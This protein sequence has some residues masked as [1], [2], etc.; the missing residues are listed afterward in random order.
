M[1]WLGHT[2]IMKDNRWPKKEY[3]CRPVNRRSRTVRPKNSWKNYIN[4]IITINLDLEDPAGEGGRKTWRL[5]VETD[6]LNNKS[7]L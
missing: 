3:E 6:R 4:E 5:R 1:G 7:L 2:I